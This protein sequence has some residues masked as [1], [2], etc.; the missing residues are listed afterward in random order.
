MNTYTKRTGIRISLILL[1]SFCAMIPEASTEKSEKIANMF[2]L[3]TACE[4]MNLHVN[5]SSTEPQGANL[6]EKAITNSVESRLRSGRIFKSETF[7]Y[8]DVSVNIVGYGF[9]IDLQFKRPFKDHRFPELYGYATTWERSMTGTH[10]G[11]SDFILSKLSEMTDEFLVEYL[12]VNEKD[13]NRI[14]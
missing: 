1:I 4:P 10:S 3:F 9:N 13:C 14:R 2:E 6:T 5:Y 12:R 7:N 11:A 8:L